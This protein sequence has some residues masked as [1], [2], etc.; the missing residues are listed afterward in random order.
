[1]IIPGVGVDDGGVIG[2]YPPLHPNPP[3]YP[4]KMW[5]GE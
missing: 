3:S 4:E 5:R 1:V 2:G